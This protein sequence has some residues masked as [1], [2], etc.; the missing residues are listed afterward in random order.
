MQIIRESGFQGLFRGITA[1]AL[2]DTG[3]GAYFLTVS[4]L[5]RI[6]RP[7]LMSGSMRLLAVTLD[8]LQVIPFLFL[9]YY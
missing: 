9:R 3:Y 8:L 1:T 4:H 7:S 5:R 2:R 6:L